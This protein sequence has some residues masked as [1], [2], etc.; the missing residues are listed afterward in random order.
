MEKIEHI[1]SEKQQVDKKFDDVF[2]NIKKLNGGKNLN[3]LTS[4]KLYWYTD[5]NW[6]YIEITSYAYRYEWAIQDGKWNHEIIDWQK[7]A[8]RKNADNERPRSYY[9]LT[10]DGWT[11]TLTYSSQDW[12]QGTIEDI[13]PEEFIN[14]VLPNFERR[15]NESKI[16][17]HKKRQQE[18]E[19][20]SQIAEVQEREA[21]EDMMD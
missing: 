16:Y 7:S 8:I 15:I 6:D 19:N 9:E 21:N 18:V 14:D 17:K 5:S 1:E 3:Q 13:T 11:Y 4:D 20:A 12:P 10:K 2:E